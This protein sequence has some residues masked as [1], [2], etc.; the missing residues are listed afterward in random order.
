MSR[1]L[2]ELQS[3]IE[4]VRQELDA[5]AS[6]NVQGV[7]CYQISVKLDKL[8]EAYMQSKQENSPSLRWN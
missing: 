3:E 5:V 6:E 8:I 7:E 4:K 2:L 1:H